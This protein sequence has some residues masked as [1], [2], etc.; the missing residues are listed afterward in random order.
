MRSLDPK[1]METVQ[2]ILEEIEETGTSST[3]D[4]LYRM[5]YERNLVSMREFLEDEYYLGKSVK[6]LSDVWKDIL[7]DVFHPLS[8]VVTLILTGS[9]G[10]GKTTAAAICVVRKIYELSCLKDPAEFYNLLP[11]CRITFGIYSL[12]LDKAD[13][14]NELI[15]MYTDD[16]PYFREHCPRK[17]RPNN[18]IFFP[19]K[20]IEVALGSM[21]NHALGDHILG[22][23]LDEANFYTRGRKLAESPGEKTR[24]HQLFNSAQTRIVSRFMR[25]GK[26][27]GLVIIVSSKKFQTSFVDTLIERAN[28]NPKMARTTRVVELPLWAIKDPRDFSGEKFMM[29]VGTEYYNSRVLE[30]DEI[31]PEGAKVVEVPMEYIDQFLMDPDLALRDIA[32]LSTKGSTAFFPVKQRIFQ[33][34]NDKRD[35]PFT[36]SEIVLPFG[37]NLQISD[38]VIERDLIKIQRSMRTPIVHPGVPRH[39]HID[40]ALTEECLAIVMGHPFM[41]LDDKFGVYVDFMLRIRPPIIGEL[42]LG[43]TIDFLKYLRSIGYIIKKVT[44]DQYQSR[45]PIQLLVQQ[46]FDAELLS[47]K[48]QHYNH[49]KTCFNESRIDMYDYAPM[50]EE[51]DTLLRDPEGKRP[52]HSTEGYDDIL[53]ALTSVVSQCYNIAGTKRKGDRDDRKHVRMPDI[54]TIIMPVIDTRERLTMK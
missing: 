46:G 44:F 36:K 42:D 48:I 51:V 12:T 6:Y 21:G 45:M 38:Y 31:V 22:F 41:M 15:R 39:L 25:G 14:A 33:C 5:D 47:V 17:L 54:K 20:N 9:I 30:V 23:V 35:H 50:L 18:P 37:E 8:S 34:I 32:G 27:P 53:D 19:S 1:E 52:H 29:L 16:S 4:Y 40:I 7:D 49:L 26:V 43:S 3:L 13:D 10:S 2:V 28:R 11:G 24:A